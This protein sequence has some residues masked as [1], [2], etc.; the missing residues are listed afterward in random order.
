G[1]SRL[2][3][4]CECGDD[5]YVDFPETDGDA[6]RNLEVFLQRQAYDTGGGTTPSQALSATTACSGRTGNPQPPLT[7]TPPPVPNPPNNAR[8]TPRQGPNPPPG[9]Q[10]SGGTGRDAPIRGR[11]PDLPKRFLELCVNTG[12][13]QKQLAEIDVSSVRSDG[14]LFDRIRERYR[15]VRSFR[16]KY[17]LLK[18]VDVHFVHFSVEDRYRVGILDKPMAIPSKDEMTTEGYTYT[19]Y[20]LRPPPIPANIFLHHLSNPGPHKS[21]LW[22]NRMPQKVD[23]SIFQTYPPDDTPVIGWGV[24]IIEGL[25]RTTVLMCA[26]AG[27]VVSGVVST[28]W[29]IA[30]DDVQGGFGIGAWLTSMEAIVLMLVVTK[31]MET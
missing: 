11:N 24:H 28:A 3:W 15:E 5:L 18:P 13:F 6:F 29:A 9:G 22:G 8:Q 16:V 14:Q 17:F 21:L 23:R 27:L 1:H 20:P 25:N 31:W 4:T 19:P 10:S 12:E 7:R 2:E 30:R 26:L